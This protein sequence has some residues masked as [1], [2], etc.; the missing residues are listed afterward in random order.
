MKARMEQQPKA[1]KHFLDIPSA[2]YMAGFSSRHFRRIIEED[3]IPV[4][5]IGRKFFIVARDLEEWKATRGE[6]R[7]EEAI[8]QVDGW[9]KRNLQLSASEQSAEQAEVE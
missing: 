7:L 8:Q 9:I 1:K 5:R 2:A 3:H 4:M 6:Q